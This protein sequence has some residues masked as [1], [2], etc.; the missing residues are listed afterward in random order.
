MKVFRGLVLGACV[1]GLGACS[2]YQAHSEVKALNEAQAVG[3]P[4]TQYLAGEYRDYTNREL[5]EMFDYPDALHFARKGLAAAAGEVVMPEPI[6]DWNLNPQHMEELSTARGR[7]VVAF[8][9]GAREVAA[10]QAAIAQARF[11]C[12]IEQQ[13]ENW[14]AADIA[15]CKN[16]FMEAMNALEGMVKP[17]AVMEPVAEVAPE[18]TEPMKVEDAMYLV[19]FDFDKS[20]VAASGE[21]VLDAV[22]Q[23]VKGRSLNTVNVVGHTDRAGSRTYNNRLALKR[24]NAV[25]DALIDRGVDAALIKVDGRGEDQNLVATDDNVR[26]PANRRAEITFE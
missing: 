24:A 6:S 15:G 4:F 21:S 13:E 7:L 18:P 16:Q 10:Q 14:Q 23:E 25:R 19:F 22:G 26:E 9:L 2:N 5:N 1:I 8:D 11:D 3:S 20:A 17:S 12:W